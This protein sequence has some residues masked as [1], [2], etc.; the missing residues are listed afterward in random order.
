MRL[1]N[2]IGENQLAGAWHNV[3][4][5]CERQRTAVEI[6]GTAAQMRGL[7]G[8]T[9][10]FLAQQLFITRSLQ[11]AECLH[12][13][14]DRTGTDGDDQG[15][16]SR[17]HRANSSK[18]SRA[19]QLAKLSCFWRVPSKPP[20][21]YSF[22]TWRKQ[23]LTVSSL[24]D[25]IF[26][27]GLHF[28]RG[29][30]L[31]VRIYLYSEYVIRRKGPPCGCARQNPPTAALRAFEW[32]LTG[33]GLEWN[34]NCLI[35]T[36]YAL[37]IAQGSQPFYQV[38]LY[39]A[40]STGCSHFCFSL[41]SFLL[42]L[43]SPLPSGD[44]SSLH[45]PPKIVFCSPKRYLVFS[46]IFD[47][48]LSYY[49]HKG[50]I[51]VFNKRSCIREGAWNASSEPLITANWSRILIFHH[52]SWGCY[53]SAYPSQIGWCS[54][55]TI[56]LSH[57][58]LAPSF[59]ASYKIETLFSSL[60]NPCSLAPYVCSE[61]D[62]TGQMGY[63]F[64]RSFL[65]LFFK[66]KESSFTCPICDR[67]NV[68]YKL[69]YLIDGRD[70]GVMCTSLLAVQPTGNSTHHTRLYFIS[71]TTLLEC[72]QQIFNIPSHM[73]DKRRQLMHRSR[74]DK[75]IFFFLSKK[76]K[77][78]LL[79][80]QKGHLSLQE[81][82][83]QLPAVDVQHASAKLTS[84][85]D[86]FAYVDVLQQL[87]IFFFLLH[88]MARIYW[89]KEEDEPSGGGVKVDLQ[90]LYLKKRENNSQREIDVGMWSRRKIT[91]TQNST[92][93]RIKLSRVVGTLKF[94]SKFPDIMQ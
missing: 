90:F 6:F 91:G 13:R 54:R 23:V 47:M 75:L 27:Q 81:R 66:K 35:G 59:S 43:L 51:L 52:R 55:D 50:N 94:L 28:V 63:L 86:Q 2:Q 41:S 8:G 40:T 53:M 87:N 15:L 72:C 10:A 1:Q 33:Q 78:E 19:A 70:T 14:C 74:L 4:G 64:S 89:K 57:C 60:L 65:C 62:Y 32:I 34:F 7:M 12:V 76:K 42:S 31:Y 45:R 20:K 88:C 25:R 21:N 83:A 3:N 39:L 49:F 16:S 48:Q 30:I 29:L 73:I 69:R 36:A 38:E 84:K 68:Q 85:L 92:G 26:R 61:P 58:S 18:P 11:M 37:K 80:W 46:G 5:K 56:G 93:C 79:V 24:G 9:Q 71:S 67:E 77:K 82:L 44:F 22:R 17:G